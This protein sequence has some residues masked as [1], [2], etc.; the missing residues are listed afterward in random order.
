[1]AKCTACA[2]QYPDQDMLEY[3]DAPSWDGE[4]QACTKAK[5]EKYITDYLFNAFPIMDLIQRA[6]KYFG[7]GFVITPQED[8]QKNLVDFITARVYKK[9]GKIGMQTFSTIGSA[10]STFVKFFD[11]QINILENRAPGKE[12]KPLIIIV[13][14]LGIFLISVAIMLN[15]L[16]L[17]GIPGAILPYFIWGS[18][19]LVPA[20]IVLYFTTSKKT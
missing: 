7:N 10:I 8:A 18:I 11:A 9:E 4:C 3:R 6:E 2:S 19:F 17:L 13:A 15:I 1:M 5:F 14:A 16:T 12:W 20:C